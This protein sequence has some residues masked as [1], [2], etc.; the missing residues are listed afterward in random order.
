[1]QTEAQKASR[2]MLIAAGLF[3]VAGC[4]YYRSWRILPF[5]LG[6]LLPTAANLARAAMLERAVEKALRMSESKGVGYIRTQYLLRYALLIGVLLLC[7]LASRY[8]GYVDI[9]GACAGVLTYPVG[10]YLMRFAA[11]KDD[12]GGTNNGF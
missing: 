8:G 6:T 2:F 10:M 11:P 4:L 12:A 7:G 9:W 5:I 1:M 3:I